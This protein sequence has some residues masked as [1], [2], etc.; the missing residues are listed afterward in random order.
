MG[1]GVFMARCWFGAGGTL[2]WGAGQL[3]GVA[4]TMFAYT[5]PSG[6]RLIIVRS[7]QPFPEAAEARELGGTEGA[8][9]ARS[10]GVT[11]LCAQ[12]THAM[13]LLGSDAALVRKASALLNA[14]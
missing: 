6:A 11:I 5:T 10:S 14:I 4:V 13:L 7:S 2:A 9:T 3:R 8:W 12:R 1:G